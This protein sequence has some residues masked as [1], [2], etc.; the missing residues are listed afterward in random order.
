MVATLLLRVYIYEPPVFVSKADTA[1]KHAR[2]IRAA[3][4]NP[5]ARRQRLRDWKRRNP[6]KVK[7]QRERAKARAREKVAA[8]RQALIDASKADRRRK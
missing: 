3:L 5:E 6:D 1:K 4:K 2:W 8:Q 7:A